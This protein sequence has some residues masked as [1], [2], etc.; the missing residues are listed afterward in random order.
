MSLADSI[1]AHVGVV[2]AL[3]TPEEEP[4]TRESVLK[5]S[6][7]IPLLLLLLL[8]L[9]IYTS[10]HLYIYRSAIHTYISRGERERENV[11]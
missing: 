6:F 8:T 4:H 10:I 7:P 2:P 11:E 1:Y 3:T 5:T 9:Y